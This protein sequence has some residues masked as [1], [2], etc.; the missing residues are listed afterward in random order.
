LESTPIYVVFNPTTAQAYSGNITHESTDATTK[1][2]GVSGTGTNPPPPDAPVATDATAI[3][4]T[5]FTANWGSVSGANGYKL[6]VY[7]NDITNLI[8]TGFEGSTDF[9]SGWTQNSSYVQNNA[10][11][12]HTGTYYAGMNATNDYF[13]TTLLSSPTTISFWIIASSATANNTTK[14][15]YSSNAVDWTDLATYVANGSNS[16]DVTDS[17]SQKT[18]NA[19]LIGNY[20]LRWFMSARTGGS[21]YFDDVIIDGGSQTFVSGYEDRDVE[22]AISYIVTGLVSGETYYY[23]VRST[24]SNGT[25]QN[26][27]EIEVTTAVLSTFTG[28]GNWTTSERWSDGIPGST[29]NVTVNGT[30]TVDGTVMCNNLTISTSG[31]VTVTAGQGLAVNGDLLIQSSDAGT[32]SFIGA[33]DDYT[34]TGSTTIQRYLTNYSAAGDNKYHLLSSPVSTQPIQPEFVANSPAADVDFYK[35]DEPTATWINT[36]TQANAWNADFES[37]FVVG[38]GYLVAYPNIP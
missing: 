10:S 29:T 21:A 15:Q 1:D 13:Y 16:G 17:W 32:G 24:N 7:Q 36:K 2:V 31:A 27:N 4:T 38:R 22:S 14:V 20:Y 35:F 11:I 6:D 34:I 5:Y 26:S 28:T 25:S 3:G 33:A 19:S 23:K 18:I 8:T 30:V 9:P 12:A 37:N